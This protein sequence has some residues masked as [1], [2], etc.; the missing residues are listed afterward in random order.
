MR[1]N[2]FLCIIISILFSLNSEAKRAGNRAYV[3]T[4]EYG[5]FYARC[6]PDGNEGDKGRTEIFRVHKDGDELIDIYDWYNQGRLCLG[7]S[8]IM[9]KVA[10]MRLRQEEH[11]EFD[12]QIELSFYLGGKFLKSYTTS[13]LIKH[14][15]HVPKVQRK[16]SGPHA[17]YKS[18]GC[19]QVPGTNDYYFAIE[20][21]NG[22]TLKF[23]ILNGKLCRIDEKKRIETSPSGSTST[24]TDYR[25]IE[26]G[27]E[28]ESAGEI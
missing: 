20:L 18:I 26:I 6:M 13:D 10:V 5:Y 22:I 8:P 2:L 11:K 27:T 28:Q 23:N 24:Y 16:D 4:I 17:V 15:A 21:K 12:K 25:L 1:A 19:K 14:G 9:G 7:W 3:Q